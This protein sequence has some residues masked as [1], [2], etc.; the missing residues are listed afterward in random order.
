MW[1]LSSFHHLMDESLLCQGLALNNDL[2]RVLAKHE[3]LSSGATTLP[4]DKAKPE[5]AKALVPVDAPLIDTGDTKQSDGGYPKMKPIVVSCASLWVADE[6]LKVPKR[7]S[8]GSCYC[9]CSNTETRRMRGELL[10]RAGDESNL[11]VLFWI[12]NLSFQYLDLSYDLLV[13]LKSAFPD[14]IAHLGISKTMLIPSSNIICTPNPLPL[15]L[16]GQ[17]GY[18]LIN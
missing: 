18:W 14:H 7:R 2:Q 15:H 3:S 12:F 16:A 17:H 1:T 11:Y 9:G 10:S 8:Q 6:Q 4:L 13:F 5:T